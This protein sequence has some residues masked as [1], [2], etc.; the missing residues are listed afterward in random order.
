MPKG[1]QQH[2]PKF[3]KTGN[4]RNF[5]PETTSAVFRTVIRRDFELCG[6]EAATA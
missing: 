3:L 2:P 1:F 5:H 6:T 4:D